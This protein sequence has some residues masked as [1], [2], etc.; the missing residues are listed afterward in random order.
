MVP[1]SFC[2]RA[3]RTRLLRT[4]LALLCAFFAATPAAW[5]E[6]NATKAENRDLDFEIPEAKKKPFELSGYLEFK[7]TVL[8]L[9]KHSLLYRQKYAGQETG[10][11]QYFTNVTA[12]LE[13]KAQQGIAN[14]YVRYRLGS[15][16]DAVQ[17]WTAD[18]TFEEG[19]VSLKPT[20]SVTI[21]AGKRVVKWGKGYA[22]NPV[23]FVNRP[24][25]PNDPEDTLEGYGMLD[26]DLIKSFDGPLKTIAFTPVLIPVTDFCNSEWGRPDSLVEAAKLYFLFMDTDIDFMFLAGQYTNTRV[27]L[28]FSKNITTDFEVHGE[29]AV[30]FDAAK[31]ITDNQGNAH[32]EKSDALS[33]LLG[34][35][36]LNS[37]D[38]TFIF[39]YY[40][41][42]L[43]YSKSEMKAYFG[44][45][46]NGLDSFYAGDP[47]LLKKS[48]NYGQ[49][50]NLQNV[51]RDYLYLRVIQ[52]EPFDILY[53]TP[54]LTTIYNMNDRSFS[55]SPELVYSPSTNWE[56][57][58]KAIFSLGEKESEYG[59]KVN[60]SKIE[61]RL[62]Y[63]F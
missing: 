55:I 32:E 53:F 20:P 22:W 46:Q 36:Y 8:G 24:K 25:D 62:R 30:T 27:G 51:M 3:R 6:E 7:E 40:R 2:S 61:L 31:S 28:D 45:I 26:L 13:G 5:P 4:F 41:N 47:S 58:A 19:Y 54:A 63:Y 17:G 16:R 21:E 50:Y 33:Y 12:K 18:S 48:R 57:R 52:K 1:G 23:G 43:G 11:Q 59:E 9:D 37:R 15:Q 42:G 38:T 44:L 29:A 39:E 35:R 14:A 56:V 49:A 10:D 34:L 60:G